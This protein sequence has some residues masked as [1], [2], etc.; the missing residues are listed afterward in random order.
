MAMVN[1]EVGDLAAPSP[2]VAADTRDDLSRVV[3]NGTGEES[4]IEIARCLRIELVDAIG[5]E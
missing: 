4:A 1:P 2:R 5:Q 3:L